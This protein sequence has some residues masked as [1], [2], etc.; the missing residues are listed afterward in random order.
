MATVMRGATD[1]P[2]VQRIMVYQAAM[3]RQ[4]F[5]A[6][7]TIFAT[8]VVY[9]VPGS[10]PLSGTYEGPEAVMGYFGRLM[11]VT[12]GTYEISDMLWLT[13]NDRVTL[14]TVN[15]ATIGDRCLTWNE[16]IVFEFVNGL[17][18][19]I[20]LFQADQAAVD[21]LFAQG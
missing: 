8:D 11:A 18:K 16:A 10:N 6:G 12:R 15:T 14:A 5:A 1:H 2:L 4:D 17:K 13:C 9:M 7:A 21:A 19:R 20:D 3:A